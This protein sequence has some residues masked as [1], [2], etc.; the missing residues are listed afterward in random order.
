MSIHGKKKVR[1]KQRSSSPQCL[2]GNAKN[3]FDAVLTSVSSS[4]GLS[5]VSAV[6][7]LQTEACIA[8]V[9]T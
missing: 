8:S 7:A 1:G 3:S 4:L 5:R 9:I 6:I 2:Y